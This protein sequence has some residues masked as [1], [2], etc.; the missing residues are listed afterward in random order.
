MPARTQGGSSSATA[1]PFRS[2]W[3]VSENSTFL[4]V[5][6]QGKQR[7]LVEEFTADGSPAADRQERSAVTRG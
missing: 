7:M 1:T 5:E 6:K 3:I 4:V 2:A